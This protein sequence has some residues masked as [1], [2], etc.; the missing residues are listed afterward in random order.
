M[1]PSLV[2]YVLENYIF[3]YSQTFFILL[4]E[5]KINFIHLYTLGHYR[6]TILPKLDLITWGRKHTH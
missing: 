2:I 1:I 3:V 5:F 6:Q 4:K